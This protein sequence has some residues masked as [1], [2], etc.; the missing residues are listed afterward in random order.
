MV[1]QFHH[2]QYITLNSYRCSRWDVPITY[3][4]TSA[5]EANF[6]FKPST[7][8]REGLR[9]FAEWYKEFYKNILRKEDSLTNDNEETT[10]R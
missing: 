8:L 3:A 1:Y 9:K 5:L 7:S 4:D 6:G 10:F 2:M